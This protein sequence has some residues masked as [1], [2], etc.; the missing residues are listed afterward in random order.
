MHAIP[1]CAPITVA[2]EA[3][4]NQSLVANK[5]SM[6]CQN[7]E[8]QQYVYKILFLSRISVIKWFL[9][10]LILITLNYVSLLNCGYILGALPIFY[11]D[12]NHFIILFL[13]AKT[14]Q[15]NRS[16]LYLAAYKTREYLRLIKILTLTF[17]SLKARKIFGF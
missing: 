1:T 3:I 7:N 9:I 6:V 12:Q 16:L 5:K 14:K 15:Y 2:N 10:S 13:T 17:T 11:I 4:Y 8:K